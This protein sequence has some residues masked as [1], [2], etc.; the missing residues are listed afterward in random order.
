VRLILLD[1]RVKELDI[2]L[3]YEERL[4]VFYEIYAEFNIAIEDYWENYKTKVF[5]E[6]LHNYLYPRLKN[7]DGILTK[8]KNTQMINGSKFYK[9]FSDL[10][11]SELMELGLFYGTEDGEE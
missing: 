1:G 5:L 11:K 7:D 8:H 9:N 2:T 4:E 6:I 10:N 3:S